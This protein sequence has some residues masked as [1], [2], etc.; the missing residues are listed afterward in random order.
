MHVPYAPVPG[1]Y[2]E[3]IQIAILTGEYMDLHWREEGGERA[4]LARLWPRELV[5][6]DGADYLL[7]QNEAGTPVKIRLDL[8]QNFPTPIK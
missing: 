8:I 1:F 5:Q 4:W 2:K 3:R 7:A 6:E